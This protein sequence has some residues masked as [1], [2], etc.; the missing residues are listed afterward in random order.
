L[1]ARLIFIKEV[2]KWQLLQTVQTKLQLKPLELDK[3]SLI[4]LELLKRTTRRK[5][6]QRERLSER[7]LKSDATV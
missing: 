4:D 2:A 6:K 7:T 5:R 1:G 3:F